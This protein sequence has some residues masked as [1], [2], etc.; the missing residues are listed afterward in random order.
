M[1]CYV[2]VIVLH[3]TVSYYVGQWTMLYFSNS[4]EL[5]MDIDIEIEIEI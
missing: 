3:G 4:L 5:E 2:M 1:I